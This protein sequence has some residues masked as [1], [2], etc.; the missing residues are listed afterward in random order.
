M[1]EESLVESTGLL[2]TRQR[3]PV[4][5]SVA[6]QI[7]AVAAILAIP[8]LHPEAMQVLSPKLTSITMPLQPKPI[9]P[10]PPREI[11]HVETPATNAITAPATAAARITTDLRNQIVSDRPGVDEPS[12]PMGIGKTMGNVF[13]PSSVIAGPPRSANV[14]EAGPSAPAGPLHIS[15][16]VS[17]GMLLAPI[18]ANYPQIAIVAHVQGTVVV[19]AIISKEGHIES[20]EAVSGPDMLK[21]S[22]LEAVRSARYHPYLLNGQ[23]TEVQTTFSVNFRLSQ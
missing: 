10:P 16:G 3:G 4:L 21:A 18:H 6:I 23:P 20:A 9:P 22:A 14:T 19:Q 11:I 1:F 8:L 2:R 15:T 17:Q 7:A 12:L 5:T 13:G